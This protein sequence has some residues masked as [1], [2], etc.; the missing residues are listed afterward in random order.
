[1][2]QTTDHIRGWNN[3]G[4]TVNAD[5][6]RYVFQQI[7]SNQ[8]AHDHN[9]VMR[10]I[11]QRIGRYRGELTQAVANAI[12][13]ISLRNM[14]DVQKEKDKLKKRKRKKYWRFRRTG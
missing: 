13:E 4:T 7:Q 2:I 14:S 5:M 1:M 9:F 8:D 3:A 10:V 6:L 12:E 11:E